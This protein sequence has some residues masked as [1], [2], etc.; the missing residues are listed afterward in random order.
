[1]SAPEIEG[2]QVEIEPNEEA[3]AEETSRESD[4]TSTETPEP[5][6]PEETTEEVV[7]TVD[8]I[9]AVNVVCR[10]CQQTFDMNVSGR[11]CPGCGTI[12]KGRMPGSVKAITGDDPAT[13]K[14]FERPKPAPRKPKEV[15]KKVWGHEDMVNFTPTDI[16]KQMALMPVMAVHM[17]LTKRRGY[18]L[19]NEESEAGA[20]NFSLLLRKHGAAIGEYMPEIACIAWCVKVTLMPDMTPKDAKEAGIIP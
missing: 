20:F 18:G 3:I 7:N 11:T 16:E 19:T 10:S 5:Q 4:T 2:N 15:V 6:A 14:P 17:V 13:G 12:R 8:P 9:T 1:V